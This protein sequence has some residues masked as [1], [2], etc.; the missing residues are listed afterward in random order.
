MRI[1]DIDFAISYAGED[2]EI[3]D[4]VIKYLLEMGF[5]IF[6]APLEKYKLIGRDGEKVFEEIFSRA[7]QVIVF[8]SENY[9]RKPWPR[10]EW[11]TILERDEE[12][13]YIPIRLDKTKILGLPSNVFYIEFD[14]SNYFEIAEVAIKKLISFEKSNGI[15][16]K[17]EFEEI[18]EGINFDSKG[19]LEESYQ[20]V[21]QKRKRGPL[22]DYTWEDSRFTPSYR[23]IAKEPCNFSVVRRET[24]IIVLPLNFSKEEVIYNLKHCC[25]EIFNKE[26]PDAISILAYRD[27]EEEDLEWTYT[28]GR[29]EFA[30]FGKWE[31]AINGVSYNLPTKDFDFK[32]DLNLDYFKN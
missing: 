7:K 1:Q 17:S 12:N 32:I 9:R 19:S 14:G 15:K 8:I 29:L 30:P 27:I 26:K 18:L 28:V 6:Y 10:F 13:K 2:K 25:I 16:R 31:K 4:G 20:L 21:R 3:V 24:V 5:T 22:D 23:I 11:D